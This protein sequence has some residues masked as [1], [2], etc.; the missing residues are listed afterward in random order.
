MFKAYNNKGA[1]LYDLRRYEESLAAHDHA[2]AIQPTK[3][4]S[5]YY[6]SRA[7]KQLGRLEEAR[8]AYEKARQLGY[9]G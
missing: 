2:I 6:R 3:A 9:A 4:I 5:H 7:L 1:T 8:K